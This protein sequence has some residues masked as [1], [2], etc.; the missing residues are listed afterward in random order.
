VIHGTALAGGGVSMTSGRVQLGPAGAPNAYQGN[1][2]TLD[3]TR[4]AASMHASGGARIAVSM[5]LSVDPSSNVVTG[6]VS[7]RSG[8]GAR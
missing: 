5:I 1:I 3:G 8:S 7:G 4:V 6:T 2:T